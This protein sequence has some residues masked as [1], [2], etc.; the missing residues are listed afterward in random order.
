MD[1]KIFF[2]IIYFY[3]SIIWEQ[4]PK[5]FLKGGSGGVKECGEEIGVLILKS[6][7][8]DK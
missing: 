2:K 6:V 4:V 3:P 8:I 7:L 5:P 1:M